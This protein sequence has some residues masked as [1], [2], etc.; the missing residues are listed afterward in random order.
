MLLVT[1]MLLVLFSRDFRVTFHF[2]TG[3]EL[4]SRVLGDF[5][6]KGVWG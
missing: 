1:F 5:G 4:Q 2:E 6:E 3:S